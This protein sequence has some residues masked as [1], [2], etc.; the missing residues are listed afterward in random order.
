MKKK[1]GLLFAGLIAVA[2]L[3]GCDSNEETV[4]TYSNANGGLIVLCDHYLGNDSYVRFIRDA[5]TDN[6][7]MA[8]FEKHGYGGGGSLSPYYNDNG[9]IMKYEAFKTVH[10]H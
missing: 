5:Y 1:L 8:Y 4:K 6:I 9:E 3:A 7:Y 10:V 2:C